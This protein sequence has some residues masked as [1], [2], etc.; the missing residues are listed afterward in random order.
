MRPSPHLPLFLVLVSGCRRIE[1]A[2]VELD[3]LLHYVWTKADAGI[4]RELAEAIANLHLAVGGDDLAET[5]E[6]SVSPLTS[7]EAQQVGVSLDPSLASGVYTVAPLACSLAGIE[8]IVADA[9]QGALYPDAYD[10][11]ERTYT[12]DP[13][14]FLDG[15]QAILTY[16]STYATTVLDLTYVARTGGLLRRVP[17]PA[18][19]ALITR[20]AYEEPASFESSG[21]HH[22]DQDY[23]LEVFWP[24]GDAL[25]HVYAWWKD[26]KLAGFEDEQAISQRS[27]LNY[28]ADWDAR[29]EAICRD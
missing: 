25:L 29:T 26:S 18:G 2:P 7:E 4:D 13:Q 22:V 28:L 11:F 23:Q 10:T 8:A 5:T 21:D 6:G 14:G 24:R 3:A 9:D 15:E 16:R 20:A 1:P 17:T 19:D 12:P 27:L